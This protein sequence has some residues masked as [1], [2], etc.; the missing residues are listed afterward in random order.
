MA[1]RGLLPIKLL[2]EF[3]DWL[4]KKGYRLVPVSKNPYEVLRMKKEKHTLVIYKRA[5]ATEHLSVLEKDAWL[6]WN[7]LASRKEHS[8]A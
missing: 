1:E 8:D 4:Q 5:Y 7:F 6:V 3:I 2:E